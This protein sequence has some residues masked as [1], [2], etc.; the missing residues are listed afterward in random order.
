[1]RQIQQNRDFWLAALKI[2]VACLAFSFIAFSVFKYI[3]AGKQLK[4]SDFKPF[5]FAIFLILMPINWFFES[6]KWQK[7]TENIEKLTIWQSTKSVLR[8]LA[9]SMITP[10]RIGDF[11]GR[12]SVLKIG[13]RTAGAMSSL[14]GGYAQMLVIAVFAVLAFALKTKLPSQLRWAENNRSQ[15]L[16][17]L[18]ILILIAIILFFNLGKF[19][20]KI[21]FRKCQL[22]QNFIDGA[23][24]YNSKQLFVII[25]LSALRYLVFSFQFYVALIAFGADLELFA[26]LCTIA[27]MYGFVTIIPTFA[28]AEWGVRGSV[29]LFLFQPLSCSV[30]TIM[31][32]TIAVWLINV[33]LP[34]ILGVYAIVLKNDKSDK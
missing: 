17:I 18:I 24:L 8:G 3:D 4:I 22:L 21:E 10:N 28:L 33:G 11:A 13:N 23:K 14:I 5:T 19:S 31:A 7:L 25:G 12:V 34:A 6:L 20:S 32:A 16:I 29:A 27:I 9:V 1:M 15:F 30:V 26:G 2:V